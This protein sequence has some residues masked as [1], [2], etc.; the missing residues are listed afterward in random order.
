M[1]FEVWSRYIQKV[2]KVIDTGSFSRKSTLFFPLGHK[3]CY[4]C[5]IFIIFFF[6]KYQVLFSTSYVLKTANIPWQ[7]ILTVTCRLCSMIF[8]T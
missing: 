1:F 3:G 2:L 5:I 6:I 7:C 4:C 8:H